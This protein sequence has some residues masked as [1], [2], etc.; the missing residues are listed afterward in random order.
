MNKQKHFAV[1]ETRCRQIQN[2]R[3][4]IKKAWRYGSRRCVVALPES[5]KGIRYVLVR[6]DEDGLLV[7]PLAGVQ[8][9]SQAAEL[10]YRLNQR[11]E[12]EEK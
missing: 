1:I 11:L 7:F 5:W 3:Y 6:E 2:V 9:D 10:A 12:G 4:E 8:N